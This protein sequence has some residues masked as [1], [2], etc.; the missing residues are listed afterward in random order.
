MELDP[1]DSEPF[2][3]SPFRPSEPTPHRSN[4]RT[5]GNIDLV[6]RY[7]NPITTACFSNTTHL[8]YH[9][10]SAAL[11]FIMT[12][13]PAPRGPYKLMTVN[14]VPARA[15]I[16]I[17]RVVEALKDR[18]TIDYVANSESRSLPA[19]NFCPVPLLVFYYSSTNPL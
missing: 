1:P 10:H 8:A 5:W 14:T 11:Y 3:S 2:D 15:K 9:H 4:A 17:G 16:I 6:Y 7:L 13:Q 18:Y 12:T 19:P